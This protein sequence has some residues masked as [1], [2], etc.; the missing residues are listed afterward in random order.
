MDDEDAPGDEE[1]SSFKRAISRRSAKSRPPAAPFNVDKMRELGI[2]VS[3]DGDFYVCGGNRYAR[4]LLYKL[5]PLSAITDE[6]IQPTFEELKHFQDKPTTDPEFFKER[7]SLSAQLS[8]STQRIF[9]CGNKVER[10]AKCFCCRRC[11][12]SR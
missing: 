8:S 12:S 5:F 6:N 7:K 2:D 10:F 3:T 4:G 9:S 1:L 11:C